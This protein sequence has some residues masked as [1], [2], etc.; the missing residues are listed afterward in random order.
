MVTRNPIIQKLID[1][2]MRY[3]CA[4]RNDGD[5]SPSI[6]KATTEGGQHPYAVVITC[7][8]SRVVPEDIFMTGIG[9]L[10]VIRVAGN[11]VGDLELGS[12]EYA[13]EHLHVNTVIVLGHT[14][15]GAVHAAVCGGAE[16]YTATIT[17]KIKQA[18][19]CE[20]DEKQASILNVQNTVATIKQSLVKLNAD[21]Y[22]ALYDIESGKVEFDI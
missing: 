15:C 20:C 22:G 17:D 12:I 5:I 8:D 18:I 21:I 7:A 6:R 2:N 9:E 19:G 10:F 1:S 16:G 3:L 4:E 11:V 14:H 13:V